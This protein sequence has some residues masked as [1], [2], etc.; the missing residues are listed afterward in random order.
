MQKT[1]KRWYNA[2]LTH[3][4]FCYKHLS[5]ACYEPNRMPANKKETIE[6]SRQ[7]TAGKK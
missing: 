2:L 4:F 7:M 6:D 1:V 3:L 5:G